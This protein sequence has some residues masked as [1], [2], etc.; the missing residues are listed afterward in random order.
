MHVCICGRGEGSDSFSFSPRQHGPSDPGLLLA[1][2]AAPCPHYATRIVTY[3]SPASTAGM[4][5][6]SQSSSRQLCT[7]CRQ[8]C[9]LGEHVWKKHRRWHKLNFMRACVHTDCA[10]S[11]CKTESLPTQMRVQVRSWRVRRESRAS[12]SVP[13]LCPHTHDTVLA[14]QQMYR[15]MADGLRTHMPGYPRTIDGNRQIGLV[16]PLYAA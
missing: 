5:L 11:V 8:R 14:R 16:P 3:L 6:V 15:P 2:A 9:T 7:C 10:C 1:P 13:G 4:M 12:S